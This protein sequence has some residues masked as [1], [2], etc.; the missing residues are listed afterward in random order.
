VNRALT[1]AVMLCLVP[2][3]ASAQSSGAALDATTAAQTSQGPMTVERVHNGFIITPEFKYTE[4]DKRS[5]GLAGGYA[6][7]VFEEHFMIG[8][9]A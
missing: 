8:G 3:A 6:G 7:V 1:F 9:G 5:A 2:M 4:I